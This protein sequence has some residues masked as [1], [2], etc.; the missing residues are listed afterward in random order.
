MSTPNEILKIGEVR[1]L[2]KKYKKEDLEYIIAEMYKII[3]KN[4]KIDNNIADLI[5]TPALVK[6]MPKEKKHVNKTRPFN[7]ITSEVDFF[8]KN[9]Y[10]QNYLAPNHTISKKDRPK[11]RFVVKRLYKEL[12]EY[13]IK[14]EYIN[15]AANNMG[16]LYG[17]LIYGCEYY[18]FS[19]DDPF[20]SV[21]IGQT[22]FLDNLLNLYNK[23]LEKDDFISRA[24]DIMFNNY[25]DRNTLYSDLMKIFLKYITIPDLYYKTIE[26]TDNKRKTLLN[27]KPGNRTEEYSKRRKLNNYTELIFRC[28]FKL[29]EYDNALSFFE[30]NYMETSKEI[31]LYV[32]IS[33]LMEYKEKDIILRELTLAEKKFKLRDSLIRLKDHIK[34]YNKLPNYL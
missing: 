31:K 33:I 8:V 28:Y 6:N 10:A 25:L 14:E 1:K 2:I 29:Y 3:P 32:L 20:N 19:S 15:E 23:T 13:A 21:G 17:V 26:I 30:K 7:D 4:I 18:L 24:V 16:K 12:N 9:A 22:E 34:T 5:S 27:S 11:W